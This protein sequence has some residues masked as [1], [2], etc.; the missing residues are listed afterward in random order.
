M[1]RWLHLM[2]TN[3]WV[4]SIT[5]LPISVFIACEAMTDTVAGKVYIGLFLFVALVGIAAVM[6]TVAERITKRRYG[7]GIDGFTYRK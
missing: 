3:S 2:Y 5:A 4:L 7:V 6:H 1:P